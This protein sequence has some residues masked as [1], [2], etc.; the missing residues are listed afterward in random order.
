MAY[1][2]YHAK[3]KNL[4]SQGFYIKYEIVEEYNGIKPAMVIYFKNNRPMP[5][6]KHRWEEYFEIINNKKQKWIFIIFFTIII[7]MKNIEDLIYDY[8]R[9]VPLGNVTTFGELAR[10]VGNNVL[11]TNVVN[12]LKKVQDVGYIP[13][14]RIVTGSGYVSASFVDG[15]KRGQKKYL[16]YEGVPVKNNRVNLSKYGFYFW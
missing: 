2:N 14:H 10:A 13:S 16:K 9:L 15:G 1:F 5:I 12:A 11:V 3:V 6:R 7:I 8:V 4:I